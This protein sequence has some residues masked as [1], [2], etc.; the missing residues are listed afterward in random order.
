MAIMA[1][2]LF[3][4]GELVMYLVAIPFR[5]AEY[6]GHPILVQNDVLASLLTLLLWGCSAFITF[7]FWKWVWTWFRRP[8]PSQ[9]VL[10]S[11]NGSA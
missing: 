2:L 6:L 7:R 8:G 10:P 3:P 1:V 11:N 5:V 9:T 4:G